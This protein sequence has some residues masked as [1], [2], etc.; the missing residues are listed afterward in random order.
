MEVSGDPS[1]NWPC[2]RVLL[3]APVDSGTRELMQEVR[4][5]RETR[6]GAY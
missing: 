5:S 4:L 2:Q 6:E 1:P 3:Q